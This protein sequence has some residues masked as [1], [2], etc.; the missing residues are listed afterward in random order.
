MAHKLMC[1]PRIDSVRGEALLMGV[2]SKLYA[3]NCHPQ[4]DVDGDSRNFL[5]H[6]TLHDVKSEPHDAGV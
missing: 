5:S 2:N 4:E 6:S 3:Q 1:T